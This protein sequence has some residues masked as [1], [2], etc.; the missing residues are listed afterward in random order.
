MQLGDTPDAYP[1]AVAGAVGRLLH[2]GIA[3]PYALAL[4]G[5][6]YRGVVET[7]EHGGYPLLDHLRKILEGPVIWAPGVT[8]AVLIS[9]RGGDFL[10][11]SGPHLPIGY[12][13]HGSEVVRLYLQESFSFQVATQEAAVVLQPAASKY[14]DAQR[15]TKPRRSARRV[16]GG[17]TD[18]GTSRG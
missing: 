17:G 16:A 15:S 2:I 5:E 12:E 9:L 11:E 7:A 18:A 10:F 14:D 6:R 4:G 1:R 13:G 3:G 8:G